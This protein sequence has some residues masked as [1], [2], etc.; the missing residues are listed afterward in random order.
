MC[1]RASQC[2]SVVL[3]G[4]ACCSLLQCVVPSDYKSIKVLLQCVAGRYSEL[5]CGLVRCSVL[6]CC[7]RRLRVDQGTV[8]VCCGVLQC[9]TVCCSVLQCVAVWCCVLQRVTGVAAWCCAV[10]RVA[11]C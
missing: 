7:P 2:C 11:L 1:C 3:R 5:R 4:A 10:Q 8:A 9:F 6:K